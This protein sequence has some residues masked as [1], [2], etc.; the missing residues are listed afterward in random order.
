MRDDRLLVTWTKSPHSMSVGLG[1]SAEEWEDLK[2][3]VDHPFWVMRIIGYPPLPNDHDG[4]S[5]GAHKC[6][7]SPTA[8]GSS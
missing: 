8:L 5:C 1:M 4:Y 7:L 6:V 2:G 3:C